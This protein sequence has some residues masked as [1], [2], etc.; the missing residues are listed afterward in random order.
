MMDNIRVILPEKYDLVVGDTFQL[1][2]RGVVE[3]PDPF[4]Y[5][6]LAVCEKG[7]NFPRYFEFTPETE[8]KHKLIINVYDAGKNLLG[9]AETILD[10][11]LPR[12][13]ARPINILCIGDSLTAGGEWVGE[14]CRRLTAT[15]GSPE[16]LAYNNISFVGSCG[17]GN[18]RYEGYGGWRWDSYS[19]DDI[20]DMWVVCDHNKTSADQ[21]SVWED[22]NGNLWKLETI[23]YENLKFIP[24]E[25]RNIPKVKNGVI[26]HIKNAVNK[27]DVVIK[28]TYSGKPSPFYDEKS[29]GVNFKAYA[30]KRGIENIDAVYILLGI[31]GVMN[32][33]NLGELCKNI[34]NDG[35]KLVDKIHRDFPDAK[36]KV[37]GYPIPSVNGGCGANYGAVLPHCDDYG[38]A[39]FVMEMNLEYKDWAKEAPYC[40]FMEYINISGQVD[41]DYA[42]PKIEKPVNVRSSYK[43]IID[44]N[45]VHPTNEGYMQIADATFR[46]MIH[47]IKSGVQLRKEDK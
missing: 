15:G 33:D 43:E 31:N 32:F 34:V 37:M 21:H 38:S 40:D 35:K 27:D 29:G 3:A 17:D 24:Y 22:S 19:S 36:I 7:K 12:K 42:Y 39:R 18:A 16:G 28:S 45:G 25:N 23:V 8:G 11:A 26:K 46:N 14:V 41:S 4:C 1:F 10:V 13:P 5:D 20:E 44:T 47:L 9:S 2:Y 6:I 30:E